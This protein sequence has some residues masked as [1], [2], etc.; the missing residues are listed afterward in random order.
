MA[1]KTRRQ[2]LGQHFLHEKKILGKIV[3]A[4]DPQPEDLIVEIGPGQGA[5]TFP[6]AA[7]AG[8]VVAVEKDYALIPELEKTGCPNLEIIAGDILEL[9]LN[10]LL[11]KKKTGFKRIK[12]AG[13]LPYHISSQVLFVLLQVREKIERAVFLFQKEVAE[14][15]VSPAGQKKYAPL[16]ILIQNY[17]DSQILFQVKPGAFNPPP[18]VDS[19]CLRLLRR[20]VPLYF[21]PAEEASFYQFLQLVFRQRR[22][23]LTKNLESAGFKRE[24]IQ[25]M[26]EKEGLKPMSRAEELPPEVLVK[27]FRRLNV[28]SG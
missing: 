18:R 24:I 25:A 11:E 6:L 12:L 17:F 10:S 26:L 2:L 19:A 8:K 5:L 15:I 23:T 16:S 22:K 3:E 28:L 4:V 1:K 14:R 20:E 13:N 9:D 21:Q 7:R 27:I